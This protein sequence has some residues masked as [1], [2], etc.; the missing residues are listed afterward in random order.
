MGKSSNKIDV[1][2]SHVWL[3]EGT[4][5]H[6]A[7][8]IYLYCRDGMFKLFAFFG[9]GDQS[10]MFA[11]ML[12]GDQSGCTAGSSIPGHHSSVRNADRESMSINQDRWYSDLCWWCIV[13]DVTVRLVS[14]VRL[15]YG[16]FVFSWTIISPLNVVNVAI[17]SC[18]CWYVFVTSAPCIFWY[19]KQS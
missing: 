19:I 16:I 6:D 10:L 18:V 12:F 9:M 7:N 2:A 15:F 4:G 8:Q 14:W 17:R 5:N 3:L 11:R 1:P 13:L